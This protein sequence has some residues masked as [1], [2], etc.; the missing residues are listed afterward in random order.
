MLYV[1]WAMQCR[2]YDIVAILYTNNF[3]AKNLQYCT[4]ER[5]MCTYNVMH[6]Q[7]AKIPVKFQ[8]KPLQ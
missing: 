5:D 8:L 1:R 6:A 7:A 4:T 3:P 2:I